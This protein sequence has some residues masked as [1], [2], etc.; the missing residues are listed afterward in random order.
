MPSVEK[1]SITL[2]Y[3][4][5]RMV[6]EKVHSGAYSSNSE[7]IREGLRLLQDQEAIRLEKLAALREKIS[8]SLDDGRPSLN[9]EDVFN[10]LEERHRERI[11]ESDA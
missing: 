7:V 1:L 11:K 3:E 9:A 10:R 5:A 6:K 4:M 8:Q 2:P